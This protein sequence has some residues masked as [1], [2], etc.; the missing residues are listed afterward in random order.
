VNLVAS[1]PSFKKYLKFSAALHLGLFLFFMVRVY[2]APEPELDQL[3]IKVDLIALPDKALDELPVSKES[4]AAPEPKPVPPI[5]EETV[6]LGKSKNKQKDALQRLK[7][8][9]AFEKLEREAR[10]ESKPKQYKG[11]VLSPGTE[12]TGIAKMQEQ[13]Y[14]GNLQKHVKGFWSLPSYL[15]GRGLQTLVQITIDKQG[16][17]LKADLV[18]SSGSSSFDEMVMA[19]VHKSSP[20][21]PPPEKFVRISEIEG[22]VLSF[23]E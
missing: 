15:R 22:F 20:V 10:E 9:S 14:R 18:K 5:K 2:F 6:N 3:A 16:N 11:N 21:P 7:Q 23:A 13:T 17:L 1:E 8:S 4:K 12:R 19:A